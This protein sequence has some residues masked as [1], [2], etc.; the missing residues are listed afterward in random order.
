MH[1]APCTG[2][3]GLSVRVVSS[4]HRAGKRHVCGHLPSEQHLV[5]S[6]SRLEPVRVPLNTYEMCFAD[7]KDGH[8]QLN[9]YCTNIDTQ[10]GK[11]ICVGPPGGGYQPSMTLSPISGAPN[12]CVGPSK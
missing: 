11:G 12:S 3:Q 9:S 4:V 8:R 7:I 1:Q 6:A 10:V 2:R 5:E